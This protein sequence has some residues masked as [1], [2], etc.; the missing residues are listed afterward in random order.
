M[1]KILDECNITHIDAFFLDVEG[2]EQEVLD[3]FNWDIPVYI[4]AV[5]TDKA[6]VER[7]GTIDATLK[8]N[9]FVLYRRVGATD[10]WYN[11]KYVLDKY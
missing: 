11:P 1:H 3:T 4:I 5:E 9:G 2:A 7:S 10:I 8:S 6:D